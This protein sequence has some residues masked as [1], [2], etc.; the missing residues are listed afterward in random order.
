MIT[1]D[2][3]FSA[4]CRDL[5][6][7]VEFAYRSAGYSKEDARTIA[8]NAVATYV[9]ALNNIAKCSLISD[10]FDLS[11]ATA[12]SAF[13]LIMGHIIQIIGNIKYNAKEYFLSAL[14]DSIETLRAAG[15]LD[16]VRQLQERADA[17][18]AGTFDVTRLYRFIYDQDI[19]ETAH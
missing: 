4:H 11:N 10:D 16:A 12:I 19:Q 5:V 1:D 15:G 13:E 7:R 18:R 8:V 3:N 14:D 2:D 9:S 6:D 17:I